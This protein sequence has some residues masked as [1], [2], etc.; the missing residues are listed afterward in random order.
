[1]RS[2]PLTSSLKWGI[3]QG[4]DT[5]ADDF[6]LSS[7]RG[8]S[9]G[10]IQ[11]P[12]NEVMDKALPWIRESRVLR[13][14][15]GFTG[16]D[17]HAPYRP[18]EPFA[19]RYKERPYNGEIAFTDSQVGRLVSELQSLGV[20]DR[21]ILVVMG[22]HG[23]SLGDREECSRLLHLQQRDARPL[24]DPIAVHPNAASTRRRSRAVGRRDAD[25]ARSAGRRSSRR[26]VRRQPHAADDRRRAGARSGRVLRSHVSAPPLR[27]ERPP[28]AAV[29]PLQGHRRAAAG[30]YDIERDPRESTNLFSERRTLGERMIG[31]L[32][33]MEDRF[34]KTS[35]SLPAAD[36]DP[37]ARERLA[38]LGYVGSFV[39]SASDSRS[40]RADPKDKIGLFNKLGTA[41]DLTRERDD[42]PEAAFDRIVALLNEVVRED[43]TVIDA[44]FMMGTQHL[45]HNEPAKA[46]ELLKRT[47]SLKPDYDL[48]VM[49]LAQAYRRLGD[50]EAALAGF[51]HYLKIDR[52]IRS[53]T[54]RWVRSGWTGRSAARRAALSSVAGAGPERRL[55]EERPR[56][57]RAQ[58]R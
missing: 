51:E 4:F 44:W 28:R 18:P 20:Y 30:A 49:N 35:A 9:L 36:V 31:Q 21:T 58:E 19:S 6:D 10:A 42:K 57:R 8:F 16:Y 24:P 23:E 13:S 1:M 38:A 48:A 5:H 34:N 17:P 53:S 7:K 55:G 33:S 15:S 12:A 46:V 50:D 2:S 26:H 40:G 54:T 22:D 32:R 14:L 39:A 3:D 41:T 47:L 52:R 25:R 29:G 37:E 45:R 11:R 27:L 43:P 56:R